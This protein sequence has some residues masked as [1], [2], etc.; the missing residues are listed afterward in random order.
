MKTKT[1]CPGCGEV[2]PNRHPNELCPHCRRQLDETIPMLKTAIKKLSQNRDRVAFGEVYHW[3]RYYRCPV[4]RSKY[5]TLMNGDDNSALLRKALFDLAEKITVVDGV[6]TDKPLFPLG[7]P[8]DNFHMY[9][10]IIGTMPA[11]AAQAFRT[12]VD[13]LQPIINDAFEAG[14]EDGASLLL[15]LASGDISMN[16]F[17]KQIKKQS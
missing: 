14:K 3:N 12:L 7:D 11:G 9:N 13:L 2:Y 8:K 15:S 16:D 17:D 1:P 5:H 4:T 6:H 10:A